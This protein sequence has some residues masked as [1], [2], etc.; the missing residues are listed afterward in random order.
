[1]KGKLV[2]SFAVIG[3]YCLIEIQAKIVIV[4]GT[5]A[6]KG[7]FSD[8]NITT[9]APVQTWYSVFNPRNISNHSGFMTSVHRKDDEDEVRIE[10]EKEPEV[11]LQNDSLATSK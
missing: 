10:E 7:K 1:M 6:Y 9:K 8:R 4:N 3:I 2:A 11:V 5:E